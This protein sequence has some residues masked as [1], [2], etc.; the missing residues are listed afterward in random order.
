[1]AACSDRLNPH[2]VDVIH[3]HVDSIERALGGIE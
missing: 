3:H 2:D 1:M